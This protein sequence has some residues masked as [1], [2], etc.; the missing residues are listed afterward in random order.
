M[1]KAILRLTIVYFSLFITSLIFTDLSYAKID[2]KSIVG[3]WLFDEGKG[4]IAADSS[5][6]KND[7]TLM[8][9][10]KWVDG[11]FGKALNFDATDDYVNLGSME[12][13]T[14]ALTICAWFKTTQT[15]EGEIFCARWPQG[16]LYGTYPAGGFFFAC[17]T[18]NNVPG[19]GKYN[20]DV[21]HHGAIT[22]DGSVTVV[23]WYVDGILV[24]TKTAGPANITYGANNTVIGMDTNG[25]TRNFK[26]PIDDVGLFNVALTADDIKNI[27]T[28]GLGVATGMTAVEFLD[29]LATAWAKVKSQ[30]HANP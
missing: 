6:N 4:D 18:L 16:W 28:K 1:G 3:M 5:G 2:L 27:M 23:K 19:V 25:N 7:G 26:G 20:D 22:F 13:P 8:N 9:D 29:K 14:N 11:K 12:L 21:W 10:P 30:D 17:S 24:D 15:V